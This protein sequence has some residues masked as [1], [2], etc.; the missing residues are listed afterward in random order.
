MYINDDISDNFG[1]DL[2]RGVRVIDAWFNAT[3]SS[4]SYGWN[5][6]W[7]AEVTGYGSV[8]L[9]PGYGNTTLYDIG[10]APNAT[11][12]GLTNVWQH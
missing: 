11:S 7:G 2:A 3:N 9:I 8:I 5:R 12:V 4:W 10:R 6:F 1:Y